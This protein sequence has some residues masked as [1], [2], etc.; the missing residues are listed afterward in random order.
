MLENILRETRKLSLVLRKCLESSVSCY[1]RL[2]TV[3]FLLQ[4]WSVK[5]KAIF[6][7]NC[8]WSVFYAMVV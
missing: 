4:Y 8:L 7:G 2:L 5:N 6:P 1:T 3:P